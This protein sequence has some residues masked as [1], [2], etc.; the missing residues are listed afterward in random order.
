MLA[1]WATGSGE[2]DLLSERSALPAITFSEPPLVETDWF[3][4]EG[5]HE[6]LSRFGSLDVIVAFIGRRL[7]G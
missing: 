4:P 7:A 1:P 5:G 6:N 2:S 3:V